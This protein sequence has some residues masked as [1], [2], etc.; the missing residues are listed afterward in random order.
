[1]QDC[2]E[3]CVRQRSEDEAAENQ[4]SFVR[5]VLDSSLPLGRSHLR[6]AS[7]AL[8]SRYCAGLC[9]NWRYTGSL[10]HAVR[11]FSHS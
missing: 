5:Y 3:L 7:P 8:I 11:Q 10:T 2:S 1:M 4:N 9:R 6:F